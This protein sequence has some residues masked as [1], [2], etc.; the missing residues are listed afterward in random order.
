MAY[1][2][3]RRYTGITCTGRKGGSWN[4]VYKNGKPYRIPT[5]DEAKEIAS[6]LASESQ[7]EVKIKEVK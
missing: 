4:R 5:L 6:K 3:Y 1:A 2:V 7:T